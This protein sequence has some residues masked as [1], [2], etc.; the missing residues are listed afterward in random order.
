MTVT[1]PVRTRMQLRE[2]RGIYAVTGDEC[3]SLTDNQH[4]GDS[5]GWSEGVKGLTQ[6]WREALSHGRGS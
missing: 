5:E 4:G 6:A 2:D 3:L 1:V